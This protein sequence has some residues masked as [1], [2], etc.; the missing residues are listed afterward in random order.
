[1]P[2]PI[3]ELLGCAGFPLLAEPLV[4]G[5]PGFKVAQYSSGVIGGGC[6]GAVAWLPLSVD[7]TDFHARLVGGVIGAIAFATLALGVYALAFRAFGPHDARAATRPDREL[8]QPVDYEVP[9][10]EQLPV[11][12]GRRW[13]GPGRSDGG[14]RMA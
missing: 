9:A 5:L 8:H 12:G 7:R 11:G 14:Q 6:Y 3:P 2:L 1:M 13:C 10:G 4:F